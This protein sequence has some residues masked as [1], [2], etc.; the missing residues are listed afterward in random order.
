M[1]SSN[2]INKRIQ[3]NIF[4]GRKIPHST[5]YP[6]IY[7]EKNEYYLAVFVFLVHAENIKNGTVCRPDIWAIADIET[8]EILARRECKNMEFSNTD[9]GIRYDVSIDVGTNKY[10][11]SADYYEHAFALLDAVRSDLLSTGRFHVIDYRDYLYQILGNTPDC[12]QQFY[13]DLSI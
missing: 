12:Y 8:G 9:Y 5:S 3:A 6:V 7:K 11:V 2:E 10:R 4:E 13:L 1:I